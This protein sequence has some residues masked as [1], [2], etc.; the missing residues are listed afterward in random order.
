MNRLYIALSRSFFGVLGF[1]ACFQNLGAVPQHRQEK[2]IKLE[3]VFFHRGGE[4]APNT[5]AHHKQDH[6]NEAFSHTNDT[7]LVPI[8]LAA[9]VFYFSHKPLIHTLL[10]EKKSNGYKE[11]EL[12]FPATKVEAAEAKKMVQHI[13]AVKPHSFHVHIKEDTRPTNGIKFL[14]SYDP[15]KVGIKYDY[16]DFIGAQ[17]PQPGI[18]FQFFNQE[19]LRELGS[20]I[21]RPVLNT[22]W[23]KKAY[24]VIIDPGH[25]GYDFGAP[26]FNDLKEKDVVLAV[27]SQVADLLKKKG[28]NV[29]MTREDDLFIALDERTS[30]ANS[31]AHADLFLSIHA[32]SSTNKDDIGIETYYLKP[33]LF[34]ACY[35]S[36]D[37]SCKRIAYE[38]ENKRSEQSA[39][40][41]QLT[42]ENALTQVRKKNP[43]AADRKVHPTVLQVLVGTSMPA[44]LIE[45]GFLSN[46]D[47]G[48]MLCDKQ[49]QKQLAQGIC[50]GVVSYL[51]TVKRV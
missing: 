43:F 30:L 26:G 1:L 10:D 16:F 50:A 3:K 32:N 42:H 20:K 23:T 25:G 27:G 38:Q 44:A 11:L 5:V 46:K 6:S 12:F 48:L 13:N 14:I 28:F 15:N 40:L 21:D 45:I 19:L 9:I 41:A 17:R 47:E 34:N 51:N 35:N 36:L 24:D 4:R 31:I 8:E 18:R 39:L 37:G 22:A 29:M 7:A 33:T 49:Y 2:N